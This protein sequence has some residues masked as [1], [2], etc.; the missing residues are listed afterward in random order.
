MGLAAEVAAADSILVTP[1][2]GAVVAAIAAEAVAAEAAME[3]VV[4]EAMVAEAA[5][6][7]RYGF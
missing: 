2:V 4:V 1:E 3:V 6:T 7:G 5:A